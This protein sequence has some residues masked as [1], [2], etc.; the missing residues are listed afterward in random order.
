MKFVDYFVEDRIAHVVMN[1]GPVNALSMDLVGEILE[2]YRLAKADSDVRCVML[3]SGLP[4]VFCA[5]MDLG[6]MRGGDSVR[7]R[8]YLE[9]LYLLFQIT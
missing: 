1:R 5:G 2:A 9:K 7:I 6:M 8:D 3:E 4:K